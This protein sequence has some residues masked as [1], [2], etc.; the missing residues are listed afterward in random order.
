MKAR[1]FDIR[2]FLAKYGISPDAKICVGVSGGVDSMVLLSL[3]AEAHTKENIIALHINHLLRGEESNLDEA[4]V[5]KI[6]SL[7]GIKFE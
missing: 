3:L 7:L 4:L 5:Y 6:T 2:D 1:N